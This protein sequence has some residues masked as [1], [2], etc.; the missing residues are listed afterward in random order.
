MFRYA[1]VLAVFAQSPTESFAEPVLEVNPENGLLHRAGAITP[2]IEE[3]LADAERWRRAAS[4]ATILTESRDPIDP[5]LVR[6]ERS[7]E[8]AFG[9]QLTKNAGESTDPDLIRLD[10]CRSWLHIHSSQVTRAVPDPID[11]DLVRAGSPFNP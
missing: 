9:T 11:P 5:D 7:W 3:L 6:N 8:I 1:P 2:F 10:H 4:N